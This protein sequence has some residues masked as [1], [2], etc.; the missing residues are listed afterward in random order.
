ME[1]AHNQTSFQ[2][3]VDSEHGSSD[4]AYVTADADA[5]WET[6][7]IPPDC[8]RVPSAGI[9]TDRP[10]A[11]RQTMPI[12]LECERVPVSGVITGAGW[13]TMS[14]P[15][16]RSHKP[17]AEVARGAP[18]PDRETT[19]I[20]LKYECEPTPGGDL[21]DTIVVWCYVDDIIWVKSRFF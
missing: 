1:Y 17:G 14:I 16:D 12:P 18:G 11:G 20:P 8:E 10:D 21:G 7:S 2:D 3:T 6:M 19:P 15:P 5:G 13:K 9:F 4:V